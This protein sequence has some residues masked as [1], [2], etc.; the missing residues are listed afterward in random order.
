MQ[1]MINPFAHIA[2]RFK[3]LAVSLQP[4]SAV[5]VKVGGGRVIT[6]YFNNRRSQSRVIESSSNNN[7][8]SRV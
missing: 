1:L 4:A 5:S 3:I 7:N 8:T 6:V 2:L